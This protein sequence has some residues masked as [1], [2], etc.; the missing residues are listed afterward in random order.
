MKNVIL[1]AVAA[2]FVLSGCTQ[3]TAQIQSTYVSP[4]EYDN[5]SCDELA[6]ERSAILA[7]AKEIGDLQEEN[8]DADAAFVAGFLLVSMPLLIGTA[9][10]KDRAAEFAA[11]KGKYEA[12][13]RAQYEKRCDVDDETRRRAFYTKPEKKEPEFAGRKK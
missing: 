4:K 6:K 10:T 13:D 3:R 1:A 7:K 5:Y 12:V 11:L 2:S 9:F 8:A